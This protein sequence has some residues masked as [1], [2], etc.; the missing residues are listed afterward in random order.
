MKYKICILF[1]FECPYWNPYINIYSQS[2]I[3]KCSLCYRNVLNFF[4]TRLTIKKKCKCKSVVKKS[5]NS[6]SIRMNFLI[7]KNKKT[8]S[9][10]NRSPFTTCSKHKA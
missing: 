6:G 3:K 5:K 7:G 2:D 9:S 1:H 8:K 10:N 4:L